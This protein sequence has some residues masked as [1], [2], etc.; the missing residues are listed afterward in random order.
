MLLTL[1]TGLPVI[2]ICLMLEAVFIAW[3]VR[4]YARFVRLREGSTQVFCVDILLLSM[5]MLVTLVG[6]CAQM[7]IWA[8]LFM[9]LGEFGSYSMALY[10]S[11]V[12]FTTLGYGDIVMS[13]RW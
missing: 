8:T 9:V 13:E 10:H 7:V 12:N 6:N 11:A 5:V 2:L 4:Y 3:C 1:L